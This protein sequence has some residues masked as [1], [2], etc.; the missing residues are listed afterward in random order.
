MPR[1]DRT[2]PSGYGP[3]TGRSLGYCAG[4]GMPGFMA[5]RGGFGFNRG[6][7]RGFGRGNMGRM[8]GPIPGPGYNY[9]GMNPDFMD[10]PS[11]ENEREWLANQA[12]TIKE[13]LKSIEKRLKELEKKTE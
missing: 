1:G 2:G 13:E 9:G 12:E 8:A 11:P 7:G 10:A 4:Y 6:F 5:G 3:R